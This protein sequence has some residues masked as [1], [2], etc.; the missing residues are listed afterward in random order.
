VRSM[1][2]ASEQGLFPTDNRA[3][4]SDGPSTGAG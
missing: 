4:A 1:G 3:D 2:T